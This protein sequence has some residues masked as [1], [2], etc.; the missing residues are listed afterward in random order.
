MKPVI[1]E[2]VVGIDG[3]ILPAVNLTLSQEAS[4]KLKFLAFKLVQA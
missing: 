4:P 3:I 1:A 2:L